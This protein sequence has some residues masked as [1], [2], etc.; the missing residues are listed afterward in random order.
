MIKK[1]FNIRNRKMKLKK[2]IC[3][4]LLPSFFKIF[5]QKKKSD[6]EEQEAFPLME[7][8]LPEDDNAKKVRLLC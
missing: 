7:R 6:S 5:S 3:L 1:Q 8:S 2:I 4:K